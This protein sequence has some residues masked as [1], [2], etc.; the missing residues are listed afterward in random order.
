MLKISDQQ[1]GALRNHSESRFRERMILHLR[2][3]FSNPCEIMTNEDLNNRVS[4][5][6]H[7][8][9]SF[10]FSSESHVCKFIDV[11]FALGYGSNV[12][13]ARPFIERTLDEAGSSDNGVRIYALCSA[14][15]SRVDNE[16]RDVGI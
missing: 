6:M 1:M 2:K 10:G 12:E 15:Q 4:A 13:G 9:K 11:I 3:F 16:D 14:T 8:A 7:E 5:G